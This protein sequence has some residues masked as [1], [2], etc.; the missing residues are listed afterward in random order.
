MSHLIWCPFVKVNDDNDDAPLSWC[1]IVGTDREGQRNNV[2][3]WVDD[4]SIESSYLSREIL[5]C[6]TLPLHGAPLVIL[7]IL[8]ATSYF[9][10]AVLPGIFSSQKGKERDLRIDF[11]FL[12]TSSLSWRA[13]LLVNPKPPSALRTKSFPTFAQTSNHYPWFSLFSST[14]CSDEKRERTLYFHS[15]WCS[16]SMDRFADWCYS[17]LEL[18]K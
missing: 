5:A 17:I 3:Y 6:S 16:S 7:F 13:S 9:F 11:K 10:L 2:R 15:S 12:I 1:P 8:L 14:S 4:E 18:P